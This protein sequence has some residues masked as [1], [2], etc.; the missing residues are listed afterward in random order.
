MEVKVTGADGISRV[1]QRAVHIIKSVSGK[2][3]T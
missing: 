3:E 1:R 2:E